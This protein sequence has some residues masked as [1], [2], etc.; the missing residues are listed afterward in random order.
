MPSFLVDYWRMCSSKKP[1]Q[2]NKIQKRKI[3]EKAIGEPSQE[4]KKA[5]LRWY[6]GRF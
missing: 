3:Q 4:D 5:Y 6:E 2:N 1:K